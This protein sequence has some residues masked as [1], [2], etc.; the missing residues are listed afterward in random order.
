MHV[1]LVQVRVKPE[2]VADFIEASRANHQASLREPGN[3][4]FDVLQDA[5]D[6]ARFILYEAYRSADARLRH[7]RRYALA[8][9]KIVGGLVVGGGG[10]GAAI[11]LV[12]DEARRVR[13]VLQDVEAQIARLA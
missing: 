12:Q 8:P 11:G 3:L 9:C 4:R 6:P 13:G 2:H 5:S 1:T 7:P 10:V